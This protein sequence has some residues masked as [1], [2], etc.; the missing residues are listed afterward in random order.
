MTVRVPT[1]TKSSFN[2]YEDSTGQVQLRIETSNNNLALSAPFNGSSNKI[3]S[4]RTTVVDINVCTDIGTE[5]LIGKLIIKFQVPNSEPVSGPAKLV[6]FPPVTVQSNP[7]PNGV[8]LVTWTDA[9]IK[10]TINYIVTLLSNE[11]IWKQP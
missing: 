6:S 10:D 4:Q 7:G 3:L 11:P 9:D 1:L 8:P 5:I 2:T